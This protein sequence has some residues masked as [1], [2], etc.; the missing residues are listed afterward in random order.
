MPRLKAIQLAVE[1]ALPDN[2]RDYTRRYDAK[3]LGTILHQVAANYPDAFREISK[4]LTDIGRNAA[5][6]QGETLDIEDLDTGID[7]KK[8]FAEMRREI[9]AARKQYP[10]DDTAFKATRQ[11]IWDR[12]IA[13]LETAAM[14]DAKT[15]GSN[16]AYAVGS[17]SRGNPSQMRSMIASPGLYADAEGNVVPVFIENSF[18]DGLR[19]GEYMAGTYGARSAVISTKVATA[20]GGFLGKQVVQVAAPLVVTEED[21][22]VSNGLDLDVHDTD[23]LM[24]R[25]LARDVPGYK[26]GTI[27]DRKALSE[28]ARRN[29]KNLLVRSPLTC[30]ASEG[31]CSK[32]AGAATDGKLFA[33]GDTAGITGGQ[34]LTEPI[35]QGSLRA[36]H[37][38]GAASGE[39]REYSGF[40][41]INTFMQSPEEFPDK[42]VVSEVGGRVDR[43]REAPQGGQIVTVG[44]HDH[45]VAP[46][47]PLTVKE[48]QTLEA[49]DRLSEGL[50][51]P[52]DVVRLRGLGEGRR[53]YAT[54]LPKILKDSG[55]PADWQN[56][57]LVAR[58]AL[59][60][61]V[62]HD[63][64]DGLGALL[65]EDTISYS[66]AARS[67][68]PPV[69]TKSYTPKQAIGKY[70]MAPALHYTVGT[71]LTPRMAEQL[72]KNNF[73][74]QANDAPPPFEPE[75]VRLQGAGSAAQDDWLASTHTSYLRKQLGEHAMRG[76]DTHLRDS[77]HF[78][79]P[80]AVGEDFG[81]NLRET[82]HF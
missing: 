61:V 1:E 30:Q 7:R 8:I 20:K 19:P 36:K 78:A 21:C 32:C 10:H 82:G 28:L 11:K 12:Y 25:V 23:N 71:K 68:K 62:V 3:S 75:M 67:W 47:Y 53:Y 18:A 60:H 35:T 46:G 65:P 70:L 79:P 73:Q 48:G 51:D 4:K 74:V 9:G 29:V 39:K 13:L 17:G 31:I 16:L 33:I 43:V 37:G 81:K 5:Y 58:A 80:L 45:Y 77:I 52:S 44:G 22:G 2:L 24:G 6:W 69:G 57:E 72:E 40:D 38:G 34:A 27:L 55:L 50:I 49:G 26:A 15:R 59:D 14:E 66:Q 54:R 56:V 42:A 64:E 63:P 76:S 41:V